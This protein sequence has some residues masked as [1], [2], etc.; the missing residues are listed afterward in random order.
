MLNH[1]KGNKLSNNFKLIKSF[2]RQITYSQLNHRIHPDYSSSHF[3][4][5]ICNRGLIDKP[6]VLNQET[7]FVKYC[8]MHE[9]GECMCKSLLECE[10][11]LKLYSF[12]NIGVNLADIVD[13]VDIVDIVDMEMKNEKKRRRIERKVYEQE[14]I[15]EKQKL[16]LMVECAPASGS[17]KGGGKKGKKSDDSETS[18]SDNE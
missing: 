13:N 8:A 5:R 11:Q 10:Q 15:R 14:L 7:G 9:N 16:G 2:R 17:K 4:D 6:L 3:I 18:N 1:C 12:G